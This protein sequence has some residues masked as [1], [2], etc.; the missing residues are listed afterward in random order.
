MGGAWHWTILVWR[1]RFDTGHTDL[2]PDGTT[3]LSAFG[4]AVYF[5]H[6]SIIA[7][8]FGIV[9]R[10]FYKEHEPAHCHAEHQGHQAKCDFSGNV[11]AGQIQSG[12][13]VRLIRE[14]AAQ[15]Q[16]ELEANW[17][18]MKAGRSLDKISPLE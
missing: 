3:L 8:F 13:A 6:M 7:V 17:A 16:A 12:T 5:T 1:L 10:M 18:N 15:H 14:W 4:A 9:I 11:V 2:P